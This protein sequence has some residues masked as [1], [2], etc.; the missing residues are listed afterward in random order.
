M[1]RLH[2]KLVTLGIAAFIA[3]S[4]LLILLRWAALKYIQSYERQR[5]GQAARLAA[6]S[7]LDRLD[8][9]ARLAEALASSAQFTAPADSAMD[10]A[11]FEQLGLRDARRAAEQNHVDSWL[12]TEYGP[13]VKPQLYKYDSVKLLPMWHITRGLPQE[14]PLGSAPP[15]MLSECHKTCPPK[16]LAF[17]P[18]ARRD[19]H[20]R[21]TGV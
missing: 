17:A 19:D 4:C 20:A 2:R 16:T 9:Y 13:I 3:L 12:Q 1:L 6:R 15:F 10:S 21:A 7:A 5:L 8:R 18:R 14:L 11:R